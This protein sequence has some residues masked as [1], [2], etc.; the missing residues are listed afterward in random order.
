MSRQVQHFACCCAA[1]P[2]CRATGLSSPF[3]S[4]RLGIWYYSDPEPHQSN[5]FGGLI[6][7]AGA[8]LREHVST[9]SLRL[10]N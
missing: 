2:V 5:L 3:G 9:V 6:L 4:C 10:S 8:G 7:A 1:A